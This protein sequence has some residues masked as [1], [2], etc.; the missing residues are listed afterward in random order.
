L[1]NWLKASQR[2]RFSGNFVRQKLQGHK[3]VQDF[4]LGLVHDTHTSAAE[5]FHDAVVGDGLPEK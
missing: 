1:S 5:V 4:V 2:L 3:S